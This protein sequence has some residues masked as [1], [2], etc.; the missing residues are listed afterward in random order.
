MSVSECL[1][2]VEMHGIARVK[3]SKY[4]QR[5][6][7]ERSAHK[8]EHAREKSAMFA[9]VRLS[10]F[11]YGILAFDRLIRRIANDRSRSQDDSTVSFQHP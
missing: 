4:D 6:H 8:L 2:E 10:R 9:N 7:R 5:A 3:K 11:E 1:K